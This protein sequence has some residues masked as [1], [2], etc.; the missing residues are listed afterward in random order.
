MVSRVGWADPRQ[1]MCFRL[2]GQKLQPYVCNR[3]LLNCPTV[4]LV[5]NVLDLDCACSCVFLLRQV[6]SVARS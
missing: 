1:G 4:F 2:A 6:H 5:T 3:V